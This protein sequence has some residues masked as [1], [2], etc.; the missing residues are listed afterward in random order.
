MITCETLV[1]ALLLSDAAISQQVGG[2]RIYPLV[3]PQAAPLPFITYQRI[4]R[5]RYDPLD[6]REHVANARLQFD[7]WAAKYADVKTLAADVARVLTGYVAP[8]APAPALRA[9]LAMDFERDDYE[10][11]PPVFRV[12]AD[13]SV[14]WEET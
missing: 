7:C 1:R 11:D 12:S 8:T 14:F 10:P 5:V 2:A 13:Y 6:G 9:I 3:G 4:S